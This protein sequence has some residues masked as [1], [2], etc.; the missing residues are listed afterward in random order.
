[1]LSL[2]SSILLKN[3]KLGNQTTDYAIRR[4]LVNDMGSRHQRSGFRHRVLGLVC[5]VKDRTHLSGLQ[6]FLVSSRPIEG[7][8]HF[9]SSL[10]NYSGQEMLRSKNIEVIG[11]GRQLYPRNV[12]CLDEY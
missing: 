9:S 1:M 6:A 5:K 3:S 10:K 2:R 4:T 7:F 12:Q 11:A 8:K